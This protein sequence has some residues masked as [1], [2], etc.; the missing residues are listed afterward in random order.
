M[1]NIT[2]IQPRRVIKIWCIK[3]P[4]DGH[5]C[6]QEK[7]TGDVATTFITANLTARSHPRCSLPNLTRLE[8]KDVGHRPCDLD[9][10]RVL[11]C[12]QDWIGYILEKSEKEGECVNN[13]Q[14]SSRLLHEGSSK[15]SFGIAGATKAPGHTSI[16]DREPWCYRLI[17]VT[18]WPHSLKNCDTGALILGLQRCMQCS[19]LSGWYWGKCPQMHWSKSSCQIYTSGRSV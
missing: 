3:L 5:D 13:W 9:H 1:F 15:H 12:S 6:G 8:W 11:K 17:C 2:L 14:W 10:G 4:W 7:H 19:Y 18:A 16:G